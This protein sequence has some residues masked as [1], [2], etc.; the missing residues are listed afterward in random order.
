MIPLPEKFPPSGRAR[1]G[2]V[3]LLIIEP[4]GMDAMKASSVDLGGMDWPIRISSGDLGN[5]LVTGYCKKHAVNVP[6]GCV[7]RDC[8]VHQPPAL[9]PW[10]RTCAK[11]SSTERF[12][13]KR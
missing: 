9:S 11:S 10:T 1:E 4:G 7:R 8:S 3:A 2:G 13:V 6:W 12:L 5:A